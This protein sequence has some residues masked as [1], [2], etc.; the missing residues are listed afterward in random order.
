MAKIKR[1]GRTREQIA[2]S[3]KKMLKESETTSHLKEVNGGLFNLRTSQWAIKP[4]ESFAHLKAI[5]GGLWDT[6][7]SRWVVQPDKPVGTP[8]VGKKPAKAK[9]S[10]ELNKMSDAEFSKF[11]KQLSR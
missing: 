4:A 11:K 2:A 5:K 7:K 10:K 8:A 6:R 1:G 3:V 9:K